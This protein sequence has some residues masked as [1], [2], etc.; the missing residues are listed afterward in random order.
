MF[1]LNLNSKHVAYLFV[2]NFC[3][4]TFS[5]TGLSRSDDHAKHAKLAGFPGAPSQWTYRGKSILFTAETISLSIPRNRIR[6]CFDGMHRGQAKHTEN[7]CFGRWTSPGTEM[8]GGVIVPYGI[9]GYTCLSRPSL[10]WFFGC[11]N[12]STN[13]VKYVCVR[14]IKFQWLVCD[15][16]N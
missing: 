2:V 7:P 9:V 5:L 4:E 6:N 10:L 1:L 14:G 16:R 11:L 12:R 15:I 3:S 8:R 13:S